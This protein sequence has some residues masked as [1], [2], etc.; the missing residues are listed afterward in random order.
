MPTRVWPV[1]AAVV[2]ASVLAFGVTGA[3]LTRWLGRHEV[4]TR[5]EG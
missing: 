2:T 4:P 1:V 5:E 3:P